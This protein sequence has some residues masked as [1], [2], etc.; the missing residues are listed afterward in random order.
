MTELQTGLVGLGAL[1]VVGVLAYN[2]WQEY[3]HRKVAEQVLEARH[4][5]VLLDDRANAAE[6]PVAEIEP[7]LMPRRNTMETSEQPTAIPTAR[8][9]GNRPVPVDPSE[10]IEPVFHA[11]PVLEPTEV[12]PDKSLLPVE[13]P[14]TRQG[15]QPDAPAIATRLA[16]RADESVVDPG[17]TV[18]AAAGS[19]GTNEPDR[20][21]PSLASGTQEAADAVEPTHLLSPMID[22]VAVLEAA[23]AAPAKQILASQRPALARVRKPVHWIGYNE[24]VREWEPIS[25]DSQTFYRRV[26][27]GLQVVNRQGPVKDVDLATFCTAMQDLADELMAVVDLPA[28]QPALQAAAT[29]DEFCANVD[30][31]IGIN[32]VSQGQ[33]FQGTKLRA[34]AESAGMVM[35]G[36]GRFVRFDDDGN[37]LYAM[38]NVEDTRFVPEAMKNMGTH[39]VTFL[40]DVPCVSHGERVFN[41][42]V[43]LA[44]RFADVLHG[45]LVD[46]NRRPL[47]EA[48]L[49][50]I[51]RQVAQ[52]Q[53]TMAA[54]GLHAGGPLARRLFS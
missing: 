15:A 35:D 17:R 43:D 13:P 50:P 37:L 29:L 53:A 49:E 38:I 18:A 12:L 25:E 14:A 44:R 51:R 33:V 27:A 19:A 7:G 1:A 4:K 26:R 45:V 30:I 41:Q 8:T 5:D 47:S 9:S 16:D 10:R 34:L 21:D 42:M 52:F 36:N 39:G 6:E 40:L 22:Y 11:E 23:D 54:Q 48:A 32:V 28:R 31:Q 2:K 46:D 3:R 20:R 24:Q